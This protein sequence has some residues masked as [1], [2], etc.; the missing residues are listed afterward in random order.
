MVFTRMAGLGRQY[1]RHFGM[2]GQPDGC[3]KGIA[4][5]QVDASLDVALDRENP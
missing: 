2:A 4:G 5:E 1:Q 3:F